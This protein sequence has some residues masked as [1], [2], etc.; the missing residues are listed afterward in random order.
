[1]K[2]LLLGSTALLG[3]IA[4]SGAASA[5]Q[6]VTRAPF[7]L[8]IGGTVSSYFGVNS[9]GNEGL[10]TEKK[11]Y[12]LLHESLMQFAATAKT[13]NGLTYG[14]SIQKYF[15]NTN[16]AGTYAATVGSGT[17]SQTNNDFDRSFAFVQGSFGRVAVGGTSSSANFNAA[18]I[19]AVGPGRGN[20]LGV[21]G[22]L[23]G[24]FYNIG[25]TG[26]TASFG[27]MTTLGTQSTVGA[28]SASGRN[29]ITY[30]S[31][32]F[33]GL[34]LALA[35]IPSPN[36][37]GANFDR[38]DTVT[39]AAQNP[40]RN[41]F[42]DVVQVGATYTVKMASVDITPML[43]YATGSSLKSAT[44]GVGIEDL[45]S[46]YAGLRLEYMGASFGVGYTNAFDSGLRK[47]AGNPGKDDAQGLVVALGYVTGPWAVSGYY[48]ATE[49]EGSQAVS[50][51]DTFRAFEIAGG[52]TLAPGLQL[53]TA[54]H[55]YEF[56]DDVLSTKYN[57]TLFLLGT[58][59]TF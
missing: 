11:S 40:G 47:G 56:K 21:D 8:T 31:P 18:G 5:Q 52:Y 49:R 23:A 32:N 34:Q 3:A 46:I 6:V 12:D 13:D 45:S 41:Q 51:N 9:G 57:G 15:T 35:Y 36:N 59:L 43:S 26:S 19:N 20:G 48:Q 17:S 50:A 30:Q 22:G 28:Q 2:K 55:N 14:A 1:M 7:T 44:P 24:F 39:P 4:L 29:K 25:Q 54:V 37:A 33:S 53:W 16:G 27:A 38:T 58:S 10:T 42:R